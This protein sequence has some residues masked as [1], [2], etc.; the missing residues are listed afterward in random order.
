MKDEFIRTE[1]VTRFEDICR[2]LESRESRIGPSL[3]MVTGPAGRGKSLAAKRYA[4]QSEAVYVP[5]MLI[6]TPVMLLREI[7]F[8]LSA[9]RPARTEACLTQIETAMRDQRRLV[10]VDEADLMEIR[11]LEMLR[12]LN[13]V[14]E[15]PVLLIG[16]EGLAGKIKSRRRLSSRIRRRLEF[17]PVTQADVALF[18]KRA[19]GQELTPDTVAVLHRHSE[20]DWRPVLTLALAI[21]RALAASGLNTVSPDLAAE[22]VKGAR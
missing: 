13:E 11:L 1:N 19:L 22:V 7:C 3:G 15:C 20:G 21:E 6:R 2:E 8:E 4:T 17:G 5:P 18:Y 9:V 10:I 12:N 16:E 14:T